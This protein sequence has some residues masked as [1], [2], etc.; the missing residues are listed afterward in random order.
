MFKTKS[1]VPFIIMMVIV[2]IIAI[3]LIFVVPALLGDPTV[4]TTD[5]ATTWSW[6][7]SFEF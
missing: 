4:T 1:P 5:G 2:A 3:A 7:G 6:S